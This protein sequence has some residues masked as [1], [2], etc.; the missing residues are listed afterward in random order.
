M[1]ELKSL[2]R[3]VARSIPGARGSY[4]RLR[5]VVWRQRIRLR[6]RSTMQGIIDPHRT[7]WVDPGDIRLACVWGAGSYRKFADRGQVLDGSWD[8]DVQPF[9]SLD[10]Y[11]GLRDHFLDGTPWTETDYYQRVV[12]QV[13]G[14]F[15]KRGMRTRDDVDARCAEIDRLYEGIRDRGYGS[16]DVARAAPLSWNSHEDEVS[17]RIGRD[18]DLLFE[19]GRHRLAIA[20]ILGVQ[21]IPVKVTV[22]HRLWFDFVREV[23]DY[24]RRHDGKI[25]NVISHPD[26]DDVPALHGRERFELIR[27]HLPF[28][29]GTALDI[30]CH[31]GY[32]CQRFEELGFRCIGVEADERH[33]YF[34]QKLRRAEGKT[35]ELVN[36]SIFDHRQPSRFDL[37][38]ALNVFHHFTKTAEMHD[39]LVEFLARTEMRAM[40][41][42]CHNVDQP[43]MET[44]YRNYTPQEL[45]DFV[46]RHSNLTR[47]RLIGIEDGRRE[48]HLLEV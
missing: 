35:F 9:E 40:V 15:E 3:R 48:I 30:G 19:D 4:R 8:T 20:K 13:L 12:G 41:L 14:G 34:A 17:V 7:L 46:L 42:G 21:R 29:E 38:L 27:D 28:R 23:H 39:R 37:V 32:Y 47:A 5:F 10:V 25:Y 22:R 11:R 45:V 16:A 6:S 31:W 33:F 36:A 24:A 2:P 18:G 26:L 44:A 1:T 43:A